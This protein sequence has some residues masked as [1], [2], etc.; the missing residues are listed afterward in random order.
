[1]G[2]EIERNFLVVND[3][4]SDFTKIILR[5][6]VSPELAI[7]GRREIQEPTAKVIYHL[8]PSKLFELELPATKVQVQFVYILNYI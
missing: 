4:I 1:M 5:I 3:K 7:V 2:K 6:I 8:L